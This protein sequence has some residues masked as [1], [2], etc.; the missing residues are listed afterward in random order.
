MFLK[1]WT[2]SLDI[3]ELEPEFKFSNKLE[4]EPDP[5]S[6]FYCGTWKQDPDFWKAF[7]EQNRTGTR[8]DI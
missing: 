1:N 5:S 6:N 2:L 7:S 8:F 3:V 4:L